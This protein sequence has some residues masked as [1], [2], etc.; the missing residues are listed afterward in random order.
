MDYGAIFNQAKQQ[1]IEDLQKLT[2]EKFLSRKELIRSHLDLLESI[3]KAFD[4]RT[5]LLS[6]ENE[7]KE[8][9][10][11]NEPKETEE[12]TEDADTEICPSGEGEEK[13]YL[14][15]RGILGGY[16]PELNAI[17]PEAVVQKLGLE[18]HDYVY[19][20][21]I[22]GSDPEKKKYH[23]KLAK[24]AEVPVPIDRVQYNLCPIE[25]DAGV[26]VVRKS[27]ETGEDIRIGDI[28]FAVRI[29]DE[30]IL[31]LSLKEGDIVD[32]AFPT[33]R[34]DKCR[35]LYVHPIEELRQEEP[36]Q[37]QHKKKKESNEN[38]SEENEPEK[39][40]EGKTI[41][42][43]GNEPEKA[44][45][46]EKIEERGGTFL[47][48][49][50]K[51]NYITLASLVRKSDVVIFLLGVSGHIGMK[52]IKRYCKEYGIPFIP[53]WENGVTSVIR[54]AEEVLTD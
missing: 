39:I 47:W 25:S 2:L 13:M 20:F 15:K 14:F 21:E 51:D 28:P 3:Q 6:E 23:Y 26:L 45:Y 41:L 44:H 53:T 43:I 40:F 17:V 33:K 32:I 27:H 37:K 4:V 49:D 18:N 19:A 12:G 11:C 10:L 24:K 8:D 46:R 1:M 7:G 5:K 30:E 52:L 31:R 50:A 22:P 9:H 36:V 54:L 48:A 34:P 35:V 42:I 38:C 16:V 29:P